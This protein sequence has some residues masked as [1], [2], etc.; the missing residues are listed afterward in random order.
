MASTQCS[1]LDKRFFL[2]NPAR[3]PEADASTV[4]TVGGAD[5]LDTDEP[6]PFLQQVTIKA[7]YVSWVTKTPE[8]LAFL[9]ALVGHDNIMLFTN[10]NLQ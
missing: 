9:E 8:S 5:E 2:E 4:S 1:Y 10:K 6:A 7:M 3:M